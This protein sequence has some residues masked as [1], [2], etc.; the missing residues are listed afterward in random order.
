M[1]YGASMLAFIL[2]GLL[3]TAC[4]GS[5]ADAT[6]PTVPNPDAVGD[7]AAGREIF[8]TRQADAPACIS[9]H[10]VDGSSSP[11]GPSLQHIAAKAGSR[12][13]GMDAVAYLR[14]SIVEP[15]AYLADNRTQARMYS[16]YNAALSEDQ[17]N[18][19]IAYLLTLE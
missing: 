3:L 12:V 5:Q 6:Q 13:E 18:D 16:G 2:L 17:L 15:D 4:G 19:L 14:Q 1:K 10:T 8:M 11:V 9:C 7:P